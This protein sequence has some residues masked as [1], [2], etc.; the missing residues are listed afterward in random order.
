MSDRHHRHRCPIGLENFP[1][2]SIEPIEIINKPSSKYDATGN[3]GIINIIF[4]KEKEKLWNDM[5]GMKAGGLT[6]KIQEEK[7]DL[8]LNA[9]DIFNTSVI[10]DKL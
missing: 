9:T 3:A 5:A 4:K 6:K 8:F 1:T 10:I 7:G 2:S